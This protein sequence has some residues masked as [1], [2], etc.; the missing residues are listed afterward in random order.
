MFGEQFGGFILANRGDSQQDVLGGNIF[1]LKLFGFDERALENLVRSC[2]QLLLRHAR[3]FRQ[4]RK[5]SLNFPGKSLRANPQTRKQ[6]R[7]DPVA[8]RH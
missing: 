4:P 1:V 6:R 5:S 8:L 3:D 2:A 7:D